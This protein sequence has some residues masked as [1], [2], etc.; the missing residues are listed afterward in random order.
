MNRPQ[1]WRLKIKSGAFALLLPV[2]FQLDIQPAHS[3]VLGLWT[4]TCLKMYR[5]WQSKP[6]HKAFAVTSATANNYGQA[7]DLNVDGRFEIINWRQENPALIEE[8]VDESI[9][10]MPEPAASVPIILRFWGN[11][12]RV[13]GQPETG[14]MGQLEFPFFDQKTNPQETPVHLSLAQSTCAS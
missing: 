3:Q 1:E 8:L 14:G 4:K 11:E 7:C 9:A 12:E 6:S 10:T 13:V 2:V 5:Q